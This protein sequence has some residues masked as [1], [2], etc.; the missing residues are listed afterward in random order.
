AVWVIPIFDSSA[1]ILR[2]K[3]TGR[4]IYATD[5][6]H[7]HHCLLRRGYSLRQAVGLIAL[8]CAA[9][10]LGAFASVYLRSELLAILSALAV[11]AILVATRVFGY[12]ELLLL[13]KRLKAAGASF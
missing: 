3:L 8:L 13:A 2:R 4:S 5:R 6:A 10:A 11:I 1:A 7:L 9:S 12:A